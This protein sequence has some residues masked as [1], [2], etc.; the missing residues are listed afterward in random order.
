V[1]TRFLSASQTDNLVLY[2]EALHQRGLASAEHTTLLINCYTRAQTAESSAAEASATEMQTLLGVDG[3]ASAD[4]DFDEDD[5][6]EDDDEDDDHDDDDAD[7]AASAAASGVGAAKA[8]AA[9]RRRVAQARRE[10]TGQT[11]INA[12]ERKARVIAR[13][14]S[15]IH[16]AQTA[17]SES[18]E[19]EEDHDDDEADDAAGAGAGSGGRS[20][21]ST[22]AAGSQPGRDAGTSAKARRQRRRK[23]RAA[24]SGDD[25][26]LNRRGRL[27]VVRA[28]RGLRAAG[29]AEFGKLALEL[30]VRT[31]RHAEAVSMWVDSSGVGD[32]TTGLQ[33][34][35]GLTHAEVEE[36]VLR[37]GA[38]LLKALPTEATDLFIRLCCGWEPDLAAA[39]EAAA[40]ALGS[41]PEA[42]AAA[43]RAASR[44]G[45]R[46]TAGAASASGLTATEAEAMAA[47]RRRRFQKFRG[48]SAKGSTVPDKLLPMYEPD[49]MPASTPIPASALSGSATVTA[50]TVQRLRLDCELRRLLAAVADTA[51]APCLSQA[52]SLTL[53]ELSLRPDVGDSALDQLVPV[54]SSSSSASSPPS[55]APA[56]AASSSASWHLEPMALA[57]WQPL[58]EHAAVRDT[59]RS[60]FVRERILDR[61]ERC[62]VSPEAAISL[63]RRHGDTAGALR[64]MGRGGVAGIRAAFERHASLMSDAVRGRRWDEAASM[65]QVLVEH[66]EAH[67]GACPGL[68]GEALV[69]VTAAFVGRENTVVLGRAA[70]GEEEDDEDD[71][72][73]GSDAEDAAVATVA[74]AEDDGGG[75]GAVGESLF[76]T[77][78][79]ADDEEHCLAGCVH[80]AMNV[81]GMQALQVIS[82]LSSNPRVPLR[83]VKP[84]LRDLMLTM[85]EAA[86]EAE[87][88]SASHRRDTAVMRAELRTLRSTGAVFSG[89]R[90]RL[91]RT[92]LEPPSVHFLCGRV[93]NGRRMTADLDREHS[94]ALAEATNGDEIACPVCYHDHQH[95]LDVRAHVKSAAQDKAQFFKDIDQPELRGGQFGAVA[96]FLGKCIVEP[97]A[98]S[99]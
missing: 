62:S 23:R 49:V 9:A 55:A 83:V 90:S 10:R 53:L 3:K 38:V 5:E 60:R 84:A 26:S 21:A 80:S 88:D 89:E 2:L 98:F 72:E 14:R 50:S 54:A 92:S 30:A 94:F 74:A 35:L 25:A 34:M 59:L 73:D 93:L 47:W 11:A 15:F 17:E 61:P 78:T 63:C 12:A 41:T 27:D 28:I 70:R 33:Y 85:E 42:L 8:G 51:S 64:I 19:D 65:R 46:S 6:E 22:D 58:P 68:W 97:A 87:E 13:L 76:L 31:G 96:S 66:C 40:T 39:E 32:A 48:A 20:G 36:V 71:D 69:A 95:A 45:R 52:A 56:A 7:A 4:D 37:Y 18:E 79:D 29:D 91:S 24:A 43:G 1:V 77:G 75:S 86:V 16:Q 81:A 44:A 67:E 82:V 99:S 57:R